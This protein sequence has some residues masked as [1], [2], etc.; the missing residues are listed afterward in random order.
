MNIFFHSAAFGIVPPIPDNSK[1]YFMQNAFIILLL[2]PIY[3][4]FL[5]FFTIWGST[6]AAAFWGHICT[7]P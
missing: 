3:C 5:I 6:S 1:D 4:Y 2:N 7:G